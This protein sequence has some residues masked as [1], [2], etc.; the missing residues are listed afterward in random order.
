MDPQPQPGQADDPRL[1][2]LIDYLAQ[3]KDR[4]NIEALRK[5]LVEAG[6]DPTLVTEASRRVSGRDPAV[7]QPLAWPFGLLIAFLN[8]MIT[9]PLFFWVADM[10]ANLF[11]T[12]NNNLLWLPLPFMLVI[13]PPIVELLVGY[14]L[15]SGPR[16]RLGR[17]LVWGGI[18][19]LSTMGVLLLLFGVCVAVIFGIF[20]V[21]M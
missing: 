3:H 7:A 8:L 14:R 2:P 4:I 17:A 11:R 18:F 1:Q 13:L 21:N 16:E 6:H 19:T 5:Q 15:R 12:L 10:L 20:A 9:V